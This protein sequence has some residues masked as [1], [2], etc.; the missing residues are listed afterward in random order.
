MSQANEVHNTFT[1]VDQSSLRFYYLEQR[2]LNP[3][4]EEK[5]TTDDREINM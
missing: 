2:E 5:G 3:S 4:N 1:K